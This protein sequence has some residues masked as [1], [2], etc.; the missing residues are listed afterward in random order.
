MVHAHRFRIYLPR[1]AAIPLRASLTPTGILTTPDGNEWLHC[2]GAATLAHENTRRHLSTSTCVGGWNFT[3][4][5]APSGAIPSEVFDD[6]KVLHVNGA[7][8]A[9]KHYAPAHTDGDISVHFSQADVLHV[10]NTLWNGHYPFID[11]STGGSID[12]MIRATQAN[13][14]KSQKSSQATVLWAIRLNS[15]SIAIS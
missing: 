12:G 11:Y 4:P 3:F 15:P 6:E 5:P 1:S 8:I 14:A 2:S 7:N 9:L 10:G 13:L